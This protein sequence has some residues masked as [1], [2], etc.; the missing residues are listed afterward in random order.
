MRARLGTSAVFA[1]ILT[2]AAAAAPAMAQDH[3]QAANGKHGAAALSDSQDILRELAALR[4]QIAQ[5]EAA[6][7][8]G[9]RSDRAEQSSDK[10]HMGH[11]RKDA[12]GGD[13][14]GSMG[15]AMG[16][17]G[18]MSPSMGKG[19]GM[20][21]RMSPSMGKG[22]EMDGGMGMR[23]G[24]GGMTDMMGMAPKAK[25]SDGSTVAMG[26]PTSLPGFPGASHIYHIGSTDFFLD[27]AE[28]IELTVDQRTALSTKKRDTLLEQAEIDRRIEAREEALWSLTSAATPDI[29]RIEQEVRAIERLRADKRLSF[30]RAVG[31]AAQFL[32]DNQRQTLAGTR[33]V[34]IGG[35]REG[36]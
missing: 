1:A 10:E 3:D 16:M 17:D 32:T 9:H 36:G 12:Q 19:M 8:L 25:G 18:R 27:H 29:E 14:M 35:Q 33:P 34:D 28:H 30:I 20:D 5:L 15:G 13:G 21:G 4:A 23:M 6:L 31:E 2:A 7:Q 22:M 24:M 11:G 26:M